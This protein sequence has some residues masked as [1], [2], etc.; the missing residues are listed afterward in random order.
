M[1]D[2]PPDPA[3]AALAELWAR[4]VPGMSAAW[5]RRF[6]TAT[7]HLMVESMWE[8]ENIDTE[9]VA[10]PIEYL[11][12][13]RRVGGAVHL[14]NDLFSYQREVT[15]EGENANA[16]LVFEK[17][18]YM[19]AG[20]TA[21]SEP[22]VR[23]RHA[24]RGPVGRTAAGRVRLRPVRRDDPC[25][26]RPRAPRALGRLAHLGNLRRSRWPSWSV[27][28]RSRPGTGTRCWPRRTG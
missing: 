7:R 20:A 14:R 6:V 8:L 19:N 28:P 5:R 23:D 21:P 15:E 25:G 18:R 12:L 9:R 16:V 4:T 3:E 22:G 26:G 27:R 13:R 2:S 24:V 11:Q 1:A 10:N 17:C